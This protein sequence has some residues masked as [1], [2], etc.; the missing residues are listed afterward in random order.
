MTSTAAS[1]YFGYVEL[2]IHNIDREEFHKVIKTTTDKSGYSKEVRYS[3]IFD[4]QA[5]D[6][7]RRLLRIFE[8]VRPS[9]TLVMTVEEELTSGRAGYC[10]LISYSRP[11]NFTP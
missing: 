2:V 9:M 10:Q 4:K 8:N 1:L 11:R 7:S 5:L 6:S 3:T